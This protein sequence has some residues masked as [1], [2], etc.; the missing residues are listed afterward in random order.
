MNCRDSFAQAVPCCVVSV[1]AANLSQAHAPAC[2]T[3][4]HGRAMDKGQS[5]LRVSD[6]QAYMSSL[7]LL[8]VHDWRYLRKA[9]PAQLTLRLVAHLPHLPCRVSRA[10]ASS[11]SAQS[12]SSAQPTC[13]PHRAS[14]ADTRERKDGNTDMRIVTAQRRME[15]Q[16]PGES[17]TAGPAVSMMSHNE[18]DM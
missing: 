5:R 8:P 1:F 9:I 11:N 12:K 16:Q 13:V 18:E 2:A 6:S 10:P 4:P 7:V 15:R 3:R 17:P 14:I